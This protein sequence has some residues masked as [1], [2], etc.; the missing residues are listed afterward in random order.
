MLS[1]TKAAR[2]RAEEREATGVI[3]AAL[4]KAFQDYRRHDVGSDA[5]PHDFERWD[6]YFRAAL[7][8]A[9][10]AVE[11][12]GNEDLRKRLSTSL[13]LLIW[14]SD[15]QLL[16]ESRLHSARTVAWAA[17][18]DALACLGANLR[19]EPLPEAAKEWKAAD[20]ALQ[21]QYEQERR[22]AEGE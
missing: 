6:E 10:V 4:L 13:D 16:W 20:S 19:N 8:E 12:L 17:H 22:A 5:A 7:G 3:T 1:D 18:A 2:K 9:T 21:W 11:T 15:S 14:A